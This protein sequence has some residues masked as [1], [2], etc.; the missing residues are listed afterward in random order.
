MWSTTPSVGCGCHTRAPKPISVSCVCRGADARNGDLLSLID[1]ANVVNNTL[2]T[3]EL[4]KSEGHLRNP[5]LRQ[6]LLSK[7]P[8]AL[9]LQLG[10]NLSAKSEVKKMEEQPFGKLRSG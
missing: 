3:M 8:H 7:L 1:F 2:S 9:Q 6:Q 5:E 4:L 10:E